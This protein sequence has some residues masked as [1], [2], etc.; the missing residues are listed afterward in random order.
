MVNVGKY[1][2]P[3]DPMGIGFL[4]LTTRSIMISKW[5]LTGNPYNITTFSSVT[6]GPEKNFE[7]TQVGRSKKN[8]Q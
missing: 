6:A 8:K 5:T 7:T 4:E 2:S 1:T 3:M